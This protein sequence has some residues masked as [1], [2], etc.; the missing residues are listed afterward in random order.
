[1]LYDEPNPAIAE[2]MRERAMR[3]DDHWRSKR[4][5]R[6]SEDASGAHS[7]EARKQTPVALQL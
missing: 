6:S 2:W 1:M 7:T 3:G 4:N 5:R